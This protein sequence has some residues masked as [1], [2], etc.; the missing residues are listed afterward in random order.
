MLVLEAGSTCSTNGVI[1][2]TEYDLSEFLPTQVTSELLS[3]TVKLL[4]VI[5]KTVLF[6]FGCVLVSQPI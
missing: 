5:E 2:C 6:P 1:G 4:S 3:V